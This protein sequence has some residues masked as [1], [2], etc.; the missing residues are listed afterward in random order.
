MGQRAGHVYGTKRTRI[1]DGIGQVE[2]EGLD[3]SVG[4]VN[5]TGLRGDPF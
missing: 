2:A 4:H 1:W 5:G 3:G